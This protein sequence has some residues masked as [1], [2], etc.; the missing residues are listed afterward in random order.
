MVH[1]RRL[2]DG[3]ATLR[4]SGKVKNGNLIMY[5]VKTGTL[6]LQET[7]EALAGPLTGQ[8]LRKLPPEAFEPGIRWDEWH[9]RHP[10]TKVLDCSHCLSTGN[11]RAKPTGR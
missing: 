2:A 10:D 4:V 6:W 1:D 5:D 7:G 11:R 8:T 3:E 9:K